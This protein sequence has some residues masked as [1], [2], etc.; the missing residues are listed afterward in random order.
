M[1]KACRFLC[2]MPFYVASE[3]RLT[4]DGG[5]HAGGFDRSCTRQF[6]MT[7]P[8]A[9]SCPVQGAAGTVFTAEET[10]KYGG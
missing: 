4:D 7:A 1:K 5:R 6:L 2:G 10:E 3:V 8:A 9:E